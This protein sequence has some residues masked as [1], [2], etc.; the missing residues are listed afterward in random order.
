[1][2]F[3]FASLIIKHTSASIIAEISQLYLLSGFL[4]LTRSNTKDNPILKVSPK[5]WI[6][7]DIIET[8]FVYIP[9]TNSIIEKNKFCGIIYML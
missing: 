5:S 8:L 3:L 7:S 9:P 2:F 6:A 4:L 1:M